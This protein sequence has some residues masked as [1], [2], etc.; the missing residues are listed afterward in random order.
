M[1]RSGV[2]CVVAALGRSML[3]VL[4]MGVLKPVWVGGVLSVHSPPQEEIDYHTAFS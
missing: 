4:L 2:S 3:D 1:R